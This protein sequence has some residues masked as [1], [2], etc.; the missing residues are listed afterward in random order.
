LNE[1]SINLPDVVEA[2]SD[3]TG[4]FGRHANVLV[5]AG[6]AS[7]RVD[8]VSNMPQQANNH[9]IVVTTTLLFRETQTRFTTAH[10]EHE[11]RE[12]YTK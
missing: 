1:R 2:A 5:G 3:D 11:R 7:E 4:R 12:A 6:E 9:S 10:G 8:E